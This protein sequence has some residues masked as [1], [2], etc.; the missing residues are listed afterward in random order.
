MLCAADGKELAAPAALAAAV[1]LRQKQ[2]T[3]VKKS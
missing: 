1:T 3:R 2:L